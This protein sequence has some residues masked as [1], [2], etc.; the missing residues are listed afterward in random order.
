[1]VREPFKDHFETSINSTCLNISIFSSA[2]IHQDY[3]KYAAAYTAAQKKKQMEALIRQ[4]SYCV[5]LTFPCLIFPCLIFPL[6]PQVQSPMFSGSGH[7][8]HR[9]LW[10]T[11]IPVCFCCFFFFW[12][13]EHSITGWEISKPFFSSG[14]VDLPSEPHTPLNRSFQPFTVK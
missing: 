8:F 12:I 3:S 10:R 11:C 6:N 2:Q 4:M 9:H 7:L 5:F 13:S 14:Q 1:M